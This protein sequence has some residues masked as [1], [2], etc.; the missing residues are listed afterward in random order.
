MARKVNE[1]LSELRQ[2]QETYA[3]L[4]KNR[5]TATIADIESATQRCRELSRE[6]DAAISDGANACECGNHPMGMIKT[7]AYYDQ[8]R[9]V[10]IPAVFEVGCVFCS[11]VLVET[12]AG[13]RRRSYS[14]RAITAAEA[15][16]KWNAGEWVEDSQI[17][18]LT[19]PTVK[20]SK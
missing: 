5:E 20:L 12:E 14:A 15:V 18:R 10:D 3:A 17:D 2:S 4:M 19:P 1:I 8:Q 6:L 11:P 13:P 16:R 7:P 9:G